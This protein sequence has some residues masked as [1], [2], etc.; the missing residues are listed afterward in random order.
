M[1][2]FDVYFISHFGSVIIVAG[3]EFTRITLKPSSFSALQAYSRLIKFTCLTNYN[4]A[5][6]YYHYTPNFLILRHFFLGHI[7]QEFIKY[8]M[9]IMRAWLASGCPWKP[10]ARLSVIS[11]PCKESSNRD[12]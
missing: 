1:Y 3:L 2:R 5:C 10:Y 8:M 7:F 4:W 12:L 11:I 6:T 9:N